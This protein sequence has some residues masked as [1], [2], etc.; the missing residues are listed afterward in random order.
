MGSG[1]DSHTTSILPWGEGFGRVTPPLLLLNALVRSRSVT[2]ETLFGIVHARI[3][4]L[5]QFL[6]E[7]Y[8]INVVIK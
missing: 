5:L 2:L 1:S 8:N 4:E 3:L 7:K 6:G